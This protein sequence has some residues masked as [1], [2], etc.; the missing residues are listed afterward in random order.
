MAISAEVRDQRRREAAAAFNE[1]EQRQDGPRLVSDLADS[2]RLLCD[3]LFARIHVDVQQNFGVD[4][5]LMPASLLRAEAQTRRE[6]DLY[7]IAESA[8]WVGER[9]YLGSSQWYVEWL[10]HLRLADEGTSPEVLQSMSRYLSQAFDARKRT[11]SDVLHRV[12]PEAR[13]APLVLFQLFPLAI[14]IVTATAFGD[15][16]TAEEARR[17]QIELLPAIAGCR[18]CRGRLLDVGETCAVCGNPLWKYS[19]LTAD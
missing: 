5:M 6:I 2:A 10:L 17:Q 14:G 4:S 1:H 18:T 15:H 13:R 12:F 7:Q 3:A 8:A 11:F 19:W 9:G 16:A